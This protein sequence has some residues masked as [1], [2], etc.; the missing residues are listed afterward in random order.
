MRFARLGS[1]AFLLSTLMACGSGAGAPISS[2]RSA[3]PSPTPAVAAP[4]AGSP[5]DPSVLAARWRVVKVASGEPLLRVGDVVEFRPGGTLG[6]G[7]DL[8]PAGTW[9]L[10]G[11]RLQL[12]AP[13]PSPAYTVSITSDMLRLVDATGGS[14]LLRRYEGPPQPTPPANTVL[15]EGAFFSQVAQGRVESATLTQSGPTVTVNGVY[16]AASG[17]QRYQATLRNCAQ[18]RALDAAFRARGVLTD[19]MSP[20]DV[21]C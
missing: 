14:D 9:T 12:L 10:A 19:G 11:D 13:S 8:A 2:G 16:L 4:A 17:A 18:V 3:V 7:P 15:D 5:V 20:S 6:R 1:V 21:E